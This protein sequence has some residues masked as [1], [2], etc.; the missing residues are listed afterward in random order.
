MTTLFNRA[1]QLD[2]FANNRRITIAKPGD[3]PGIDSLYVDFDITVS[4]DKE[5][6]RAKI[7][8]R[9][10]N[11][12]NRNLFSAEH[13]GVELSAGYNGEVKLLFRGVT[14]NVTHNHLRTYWET[15]LYVGDGEK[16]YGTK[17]IN[18]SYAKGTRIFII[19]RD[20]AKALGLPNEV[21]FTDFT[22]K[23]LKG[24]SFAGLVKDELTKLTEE[25]SLQ[26]SIQ[27]EKLEVTPKG[28]PI[29][30]QPRATV[31][32]SDTGMIGSP[33]LVERQTKKPETK[34]PKKKKKKKK[35]EEKKE[36]IVGVRVTSLLNPE[37]YPNR[38]IKI[39]PQRTQTD[40]LGKLMEA[41]V[42][43]VSAEG[44]W[45]VDKVHFFGDNMTGPFH[46]EAEAD[47]LK[48]VL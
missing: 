45:L 43:D 12:T 44:I 9:N 15:V 36:R 8:I 16:Q 4:R 3:R 13:Q 28:E 20:M 37:I 14:T 18:K 5:P 30:S 35:E 33:Q 38:L 10:L 24:R 41:K 34:E 40:T 7:S 26:W 1:L 6:N 21:I 23:L 27:Q 29:I 47:I 46:V 25:Y 2:V 19:L 22:A 11:D 32:S 48:Q 31:L 42:P 17:R 39:V